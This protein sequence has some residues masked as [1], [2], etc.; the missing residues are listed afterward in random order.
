[1]TAWAACRFQLKCHLKSPLDPLSSL[2][3]VSLKAQ[4]ILQFCRLGILIDIRL[5]LRSAG[6]C[7]WGRTTCLVFSIFRCSNRFK[8]AC[9]WT[10]PV[11]LLWPLLP[12]SSIFKDP[13]NYNEPTQI[14]QTK[15]IIS[16]NSICYFRFPLPCKQIYR[17]QGLGCTYFG[18]HTSPS[19][20]MLLWDVLGLHKYLE[21]YWDSAYVKLRKILSNNPVRK[22]RTN[23]SDY[24]KV[25]PWGI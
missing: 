6:L 24:L 19:G 5:K 25:F 12:S 8:S 22:N 23:S 17:F 2:Q 21:F 11:H 18:G 10:L 3:F 20:S 13:C 9:N 16:L 1:M 7:L 4:Y 15:L 14:F